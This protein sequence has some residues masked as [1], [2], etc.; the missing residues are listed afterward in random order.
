LRNKHLTSPSLAD[1]SHRTRQ[2]RYEL[3]RSVRRSGETEGRGTEEKK[4]MSEDKVTRSEIEKSEGEG[5]GHRGKKG[6]KKKNRGKWRRQ[7]SGRTR[8]RQRQTE[9]PRG[10]GRLTS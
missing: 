4:E 3:R 6:G 7:G 10:D 8:N 5:R 1:V 2:N 9:G